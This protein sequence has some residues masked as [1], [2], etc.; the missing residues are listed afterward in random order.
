MRRR[1]CLWG[2]IG[3]AGFLVLCCALGYFVGLPWVQNTVRDQLAEQLS[4]QV[5][6]Q[7]DAQLPEGAPVG[8]G[9][10]RLSLSDIEQ[11]IAINPD[12]STVDAIDIR[13]EG[14]EIVLS[15]A[16]SWETV[17][18]R[19]TPMA[20]PGGEFEMTGMRSTGG[21]LDYLLP[22]DRLGAAIE[23]GINAYLQAQGLQLQD[24][25]LEG[26]DLVFDIVGR[27]SAMSL[28]SPFRGA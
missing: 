14:D 1:G 27:T 23:R 20:G 11:Q 17:E 10:Y 15:L 22:P 7:L 13:A 26:N 18:Y 8:E 5:A 4:T 21:R 2:L 28:A 6:R 24:V 9:V 25:Y 19:G 16:S 3:V 12:A